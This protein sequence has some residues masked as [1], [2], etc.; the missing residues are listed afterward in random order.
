MKINKIVQLH[1][2]N[3][4]YNG[5]IKQNKINN[6]KGEKMT[7]EFFNDESAYTLKKTVSPE[8]K[9]KILARLGRVTLKIA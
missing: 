4:C 6:E 7:F 1:F 2:S 3:T 8:A 5:R 9:A